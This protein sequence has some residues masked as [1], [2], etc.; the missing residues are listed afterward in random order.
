MQVNIFGCC[1]NTTRR[2][3]RHA[4]EAS[5]TSQ[6]NETSANGFWEIP[7]SEEDGQRYCNEADN[8]HW[9]TDV[10]AIVCKTTHTGNN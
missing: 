10:Q 6:E 2:Q 5:I 1:I 9:Y 3:H 7:D 4:A 8:S